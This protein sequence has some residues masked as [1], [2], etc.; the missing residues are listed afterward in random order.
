MKPILTLM[1]GQEPK[2]A[3]GTEDEPYPTL[4]RPTHPTLLLPVVI[5]STAPT[6][7]L[8]HYLNAHNHTIAY[9]VPQ[10][11]G[12]WRQKRGPLPRLGSKEP[13]AQGQPCAP[14]AYHNKQHQ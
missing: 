4:P 10:V 12:V 7:L 2:G 14:L 9:G 11:K 13:S 3:V 8:I 5:P 6:G 1:L